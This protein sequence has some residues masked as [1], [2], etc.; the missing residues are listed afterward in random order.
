MGAIA[1]G[2]VVVLNQTVIDSLR[3]S[4]E[5]LDAAIRAEAQE[6]R[7]RERLYRGD[8]PAH[9]VT[10][11]VVILVD[12]GLATGASM[13]A[14]ARAVRGLHPARVVVAVPVAAAQTCAALQ[15]ETDEVICLY[16]PDP[17]IAVGMWYEDFSQTTDEQVCDLLRVP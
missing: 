8:R 15:A 1:T 6:L 5:A 7:R 14:A 13:R 2:N 17:F 12:D 11:R 10:G 3:L 16:Q 9:D 4:G